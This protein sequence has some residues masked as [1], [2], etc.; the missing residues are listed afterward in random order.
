MLIYKKL[1]GNRLEIFLYIYIPAFYKLT[2][3]SYSHLNI[4]A[5]ASK[6]PLKPFPLKFNFTRLILSVFFL[7]P[8]HFC[9]QI[10]PSSVV[11][12]EFKFN[13]NRIQCLTDDQRQD[14]LNDIKSNISSLQL[15]NRL[16][17]DEV[18][19]RAPTTLFSW[20][21]KMKDGLPYNDV[22]GISN[23]VDH[24]SEYPN[25]VLDYNCG[26]KTY[27]TNAGY[28]HMGVDIFSW[29]FGWKMMDNDEVEI[30][31]AAPGQII[32]IGRSQA[33]RSCAF[34]NNIWN[35]VYVQHADGSV[36]MYGHMKKDS[37]T[38]KNVGDTV[39]RGEYLGIVGSSGNSTGPHLHFEVYS[40]VALNGVGQDVLIDPYAGDCNDMNSESWWENQKPYINTNINAVM[41]HSAPPVF[42]NCPDQE[43]THI[44]NAFEPG[45]SAHIAIYLRDQ[46]AGTSINLQVLRP[47]GTLFHTW[48]FNLVQNYT[49]SWWYWIIEELPSV[50]GEWT[51][52]ATYNGQIVDHKFTVGTLGVEDKEF[53]AI[54]IYP[55][56]SNDVVNIQSP[57]LV[58]KASV[59]DVLGKTVMTRVNDTESIKEIN[60]ESLSKGL[61]FLSLEGDAHQKKIIK[62]IKE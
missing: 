13:E 62:L 46:I 50:N 47:N 12:G 38:S 30:I 36:A 40:E 31:A 44:K 11:G 55:N 33:D 34:N 21:V 27:D 28:N 59:V 60:L 57:H 61:Y 35:A 45:E 8:M 20:P 56:P 29:P 10:A 51:W 17:Y 49:S 25:K 6:Q 48:D 2:G 54:S 39:E 5:M 42:P 1:H 32:S 18:Q 15:Q 4:S 43:T 52:R 14:V 24:N 23:Y 26:T 22:W 37:P 16:N 7:N 53:N 41:T 3:F 58:K 19:K 9:A